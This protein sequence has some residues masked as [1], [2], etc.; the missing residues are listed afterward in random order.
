MASLELKQVLLYPKRQSF[1]FHVLV[2]SFF[3]YSCKISLIEVQLYS[4]SSV[5]SKQHAGDSFPEKKS[6]LKVSSMQMK[7]KAVGNFTSNAH[8]TIRCYLHVNKTC[9]S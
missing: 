8:G 9:L 6:A 7:H 1:V 2:C 5:T 3:I 4:Q